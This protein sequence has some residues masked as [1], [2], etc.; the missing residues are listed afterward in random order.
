MISN[1]LKLDIYKF[2]S[3]DYRIGIKAVRLGHYVATDGNRWYFA[4]QNKNPV[5]MVT[6]MV[7]PTEF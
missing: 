3:T 1:V 5:G 4:K 7:I 6:K 2:F